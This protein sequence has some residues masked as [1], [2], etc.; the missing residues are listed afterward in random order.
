MDR[1]GRAGKVFRYPYSKG[2]D[3]ASL[4]DQTTTVP[5]LL[6]EMLDQKLSAMLCWI[7]SGL[8]KLL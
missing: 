8:T 7:L 2:R 6:V 4:K 1:Q 5:A 3:T